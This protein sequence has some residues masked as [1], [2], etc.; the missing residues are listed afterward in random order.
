MS[1]RWN[2][3]TKT[4]QN[5][6]GPG[7]GSGGAETIIYALFSPRRLEDA[8]TRRT[9]LKMQNAICK[10]SITR[11]I[12]FCISNYFSPCLRVSLLLPEKFSLVNRRHRAF[13]K[14]AAQAVA[15][16]RKVNGERAAAR[17]A[18]FYGR[19]KP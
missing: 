11:M 10:I 1:S 9:E 7:A 16:A 15:V 2:S 17:G 8:E 12:Y 5:G 19:S 4:R 6:W 13:Q 3:E 14:R 18:D